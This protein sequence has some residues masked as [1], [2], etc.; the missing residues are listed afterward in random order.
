MHPDVKAS[1]DAY[2]RA[3]GEF[4]DSVPIEARDNINIFKAM[5]FWRGITR[6]GHGATMNEAI[7]DVV[8][9]FT[10]LPVLKDYEFRRSG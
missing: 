10:G 9:Q 6:I 7:D 8:K 3:T 5:I 2:D 1:L 4:L